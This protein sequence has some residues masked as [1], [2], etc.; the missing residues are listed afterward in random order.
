VVHTSPFGP[1][2]PTASFSPYRG[3]SRQP[4]KAATPHTR[5]VPGVVDNKVCVGPVSVN[6][7]VVVGSG[8]RHQ[9]QVSLSSYLSRRIECLRQEVLG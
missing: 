7:K 5:M 4:S 8:N 2:L 1:V 9:A 3:P 6:Q